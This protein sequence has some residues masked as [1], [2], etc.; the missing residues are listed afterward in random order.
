MASQ[1]GQT[2]MLNVASPSGE[3]LLPSWKYSSK[4]HQEEVIFL[5]AKVEKHHRKLAV[6]SQNGFSTITSDN[7]DLGIISH[8]NLTLEE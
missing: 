1:Q 8:T 5:T 6:S 4:E 7:C 3:R 2:T